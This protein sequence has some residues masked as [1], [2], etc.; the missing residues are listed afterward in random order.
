VGEPLADFKGVL[1]GTPE[2][3]GKGAPLMEERH[4]DR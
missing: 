4:G 1:T 2:Y 3:Y